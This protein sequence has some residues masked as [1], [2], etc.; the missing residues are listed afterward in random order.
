MLK[1]AIEVLLRDVLV[2]Y[3]PTIRIDIKQVGIRC[4]AIN[5]QTVRLLSLFGLISILWLAHRVDQV[6]ELCTH[7]RV[8]CK[9]LIGLIFTE[10]LSLD[11]PAS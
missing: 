9:E 8:H 1:G 3:R 5:L 10:A 2:G 6:F 11:K 4:G 7:A